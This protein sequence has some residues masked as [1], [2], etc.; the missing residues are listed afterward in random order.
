MMTDPG[1]TRARPVLFLLFVFTAINFADKGVLGLAAAPIT[2]ELGLSAAQFGLIGSSFYL[3]FVPAAIVFGFVGNRVAPK[4]LFA[5]IALLW[6]VAQLPILIPAAGFAV[7]LATRVLLGVGEGPTV[8]VANHTAFSL[9]PPTQ[10]ALPAAIIASGAAAGVII[11]AP[12]LQLAITGLGWRWAFGIL[13]VIGIAWLVAWFAIGGSGQ[14]KTATAVVP[15]AAIEHMVDVPPQQRQ[16]YW[17]LLRTGTWLGS[18]ISCFAAY[19]TLSV[20]LTFLPLFLQQEAGYSRTTVSYLLGLPSLVSFVLVLTAGVVSQRLVNR[21]VSPRVAQGVLGGL[22]TIVA[23]LAMLL[24]GQAP[25][26]IL[27]L[28]AMTF[29]FSAFS[30][31][32]P[33]SAAS[34]ADVVP[35]SQRSAVLGLWYG[36]ASVASIVSPFVSGLLIDAAPSR[37]VG[38]GWAFGLAAALLILG[39]LVAVL[40][41]NPG[42]D[43]IL[44]QRLQGASRAR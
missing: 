24:L 1:R 38:F 11:G 40:V 44:L 36:V 20:A 31:Q 3:L 12:L 13:G 33:L 21:G 8:G 29:G 34:I 18:T 30:M 28:V 14:H 22:A 4:W 17:R 42:R 6:A 43:A 27:L 7:L 26:G 23:G 41:V 2:E 37:S 10:R 35:D 16:P 32:I 5:A 19:W 39:G 9:F 25:A 15:E